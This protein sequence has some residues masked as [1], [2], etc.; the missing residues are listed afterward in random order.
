LIYQLPGSLLPG[1]TVVI[2]PLISLMQDQVSALSERGVAASY[3]ASTLE[4]SELRRRMS[5][6]ARGAY[7]LIY[8]APERLTFPGFRSLLADLDCPLV[9]IDEAHCIS[10]W[11]HDFR[12]E[13]LQIG[14][15]LKQL[16]RART[17]ACTATATPVVRDEILERLGLDADTPQ[18]LRGFARP[19]LAL[20]AREVKSKREREQHVDAVLAE[21]LGAPG[22]GRGAAIVY[23]PTRKSSEEEATRLAKAGW[24]ATA[25]HAG[26]P[27]AARD[28]IQAAFA[29]GDSEVVA[30]TNAFGM[31][32]DRADVR[33]VI[34]LAPPGSIE[35]YYQE[36]GRAGRDGADA[37]GLLL[38]NP[39]DMPLRRHLIESDVD[40]RAVDPEVVRHKWNVF[41]ELMRWA[42]GG[43]CRHDAIL[44]YFGDEE[45]TL[46]GCGHCDVC[47]DLAGREHDDP[48][49]V[50]EVVR[51]A[52]SAVARIHARFGIAA[53]AKLLRGDADPRLQSSG[54]DRT[55][56]FGI[57]ADRDEDWL[58]RLLRR[59]V[60]AGWVDFD[61][62]DRPVVVLT[63]DGTAVMRGD[64]PARLLLPTSHRARP[65]APASHHRSGAPAVL[66]D[67]LDGLAGEVFEALRLYRREAS[68]REGVPPYVVASDR[69]LR[70]LAQLR[71]RSSAELQLAH[72]I[73]PSKAEK[74]GAELLAV[75]RRVEQTHAPTTPP[76]ATTQ[77]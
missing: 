70:D 58:L 59:C 66:P 54:L 51:K 67:E 30:A 8:A 24:R 21:S 60:T 68:H 39:G 53:A 63:E 52:L 33:A 14:D 2:S 16:P 37:V 75:I 71:P 46:E 61:G 72:G 27:G 9:A 31:G 7:K 36:V 73:G 50:T 22:A 38:V 43:S 47:L 6:A 55:R 10:Q 41:L 4:P 1:T 69:S 77:P 13:Y 65:P 34:H 64:R 18:I 26:L 40:G 32:I 48:E 29:S 15:L 45:E 20:R 44:R 62:G 76:P 5:E 42:E 28:S 11:G 12:P 56:T 23:V 74:Y 57:L 17:L 19:N 3:L 25:Y 35:A 49:Q